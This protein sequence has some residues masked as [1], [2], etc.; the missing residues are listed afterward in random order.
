MRALVRPA[1]GVLALA[2]AVS[3]AGVVSQAGELA[4]WE[5][6]LETLRGTVV[7]LSASVGLWA[8]TM[9][10]AMIDNLRGVT[11]G[12]PFVTSDDRMTPIAILFGLLASYAFLVGGGPSSLVRAL[13]SPLPARPALALAL[14]AVRGIELAVALGAPLVAVSLVV[15]VA[16]L[17]IARAATP[18]SL[19]ALIAP[20]RSWVMLLAVGV[21]LSRLEPLIARIALTLS[22][23]P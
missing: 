18:A 14:D 15:E 20:L 19:T 16:S 10:G 17:V 13:S 11:D 5:L 23:R 7:A 6:A 22:P 3:V 4:P 9:S 21:I 1:R 12:H 8:V 2:L